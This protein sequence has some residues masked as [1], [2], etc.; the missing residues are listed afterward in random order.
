MSSNSTIGKLM[1]KL[2]K[3][4]KI[5]EINEKEA[6]EYKQKINEHM[7]TFDLQKKVKLAM[8]KKDFMNYQF[9]S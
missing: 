9:G 7:K 1:E 2:R 5:N 4:G 6:S 3:E 8:D